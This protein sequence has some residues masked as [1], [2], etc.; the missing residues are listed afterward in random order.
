M[1]ARLRAP[2]LPTLPAS[3]GRVGSGARAN[4]KTASRAT[5]RTNVFCHRGPRRRRQRRRRGHALT[6]D[7][8]MS[9][10]ASELHS[11]RPGIVAIAS[12]ELVFQQLIFQR[13][14]PNGRSDWRSSPPAAKSARFYRCGSTKSRPP[15]AKL[16]CR[17][18]FPQRRRNSKRKWGSKAPPASVVAPAN[19]MPRRSR[20]Q[21]RSKNQSRRPGTSP[22]HDPVE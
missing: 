19:G 22:G 8:S 14:L 3:P 1:H 18:A 17:R 7:S 6:S 5:P 20:V 21:A 9:E 2:P 12:K 11:S 13:R 4:Q 15:A 10:A 16:Q